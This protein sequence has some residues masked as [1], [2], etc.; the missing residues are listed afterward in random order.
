[1][2]EEGL[3]RR[4]AADRK[5]MSMNPHPP[6]VGDLFTTR[7]GE[8]TSIG[9]KSRKVIY[10]VRAVVDSIEDEEYGWLYEVVFK[11]WNPR[12][13]YRYVLASCHEL[14]LGSYVPAKRRRKKAV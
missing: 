14:G 12:K 7:Y 8:F 13:G 9:A 2:E 11:F 3:G 5:S 4:L 6:K 10:E 1:M